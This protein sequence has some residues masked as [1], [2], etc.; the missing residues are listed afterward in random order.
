M[1][2]GLSLGVGREDIGRKAHSI[3]G[4]PVVAQWVKNLTGI[5]K[6]VGTIPGLS[7]WVKDP[8]SL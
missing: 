5:H 2:A 6:D 1:Q 4:V 8:A 3:Q 7:Q